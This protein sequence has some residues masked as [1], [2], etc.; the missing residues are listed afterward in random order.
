[1]K[2]LLLMSLIFIVLSLGLSVGYSQ[3][4]EYADVIGQKTIAWDA[5]PPIELADIITYQIF[6]DSNA[7]GE[8]MVGETDLLIFTILFTQEGEYKVGVRTKREVILSSF[9][10]ITLSDINWS[11]EDIPTGATPNPFVIRFIKGITAPGN[12]RL[13]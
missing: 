7:T 2:K 4:I 6:I 8:V 13:Q 5:T 3:S 11:D 1:M 10:E 12:L 9:I